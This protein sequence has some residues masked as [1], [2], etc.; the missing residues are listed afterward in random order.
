MDGIDGALVRITGRGLAMRADV[1]RWA[2]RSLGRLGEGL[3]EMASQNPLPARRIC[4][5]SRELALE[6]ARLVKELVRAE[7]IDLVCAHGQTV[8]HAP[9]LS[10]QLMNG[11]V[12]AHEVGTRVVWDLRG[13]D[14]AAGGQG[15]P[16][17]PLADWVLFRAA[18]A[19][20]IVNLGG[21]CN[22]TFLPGES[23]SPS[24]IRGG[25]VCACNQILDAV[26]RRHLG[27]PFDRD[28]AAAMS[29]APIEPLVNDLKAMLTRQAGLGR[30][31][32]TG[33]EHERW[34]ALQTDVRAED[35]AR[36]ACEA[37]GSVIADRVRGFGDV[38]LA[39]GG[40]RNAALLDTICRHVG[41]GRNKEPMVKLTNACGVDS[42]AR[43]AVC[44]AVLGALC[45]D[46]V[47]I[48]LPAI[49]GIPSTN[50][51]TVIS[52]VWA[53]TRR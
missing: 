43:E 48:T 53:G 13:A 11:P 7:T 31:L 45:D 47:P 28:G 25:D 24:E 5:L 40:C 6:H 2:S 33:D 16:I 20:A 38:L 21:F 26:A 30:S 42:Q 39:G 35:L 22:V 41:L 51:R 9:P 37:V 14:L 15:A 52:G 50:D 1:V 44:F 3:R 18:S 8:V 49:T 32:G 10:W 4:A 29:G 27:L 19:R 23:A 46:G 12:L 36:S 17:T 34:S